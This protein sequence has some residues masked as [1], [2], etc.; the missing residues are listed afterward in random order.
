MKIHLPYI[1]ELDNC[2]TADDIVTLLDSNAQ[3]ESISSL[4]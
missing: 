2:A 3:R 4:N 1:P